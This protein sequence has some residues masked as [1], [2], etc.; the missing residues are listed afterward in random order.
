M[1]HAQLLAAA[2]WGPTATV[3]QQV[4]ATSSDEQPQGNVWIVVAATVALLAALV[5]MA[6]LGRRRDR[7]LR[8]PLRTS[9]TPA[10]PPG[11]AGPA[12]AAPRAQSGIGATG[13]AAR[14]GQQPPA[15]GGTRSGRPSGGPATAKPKPKPK[16]KPQKH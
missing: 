11:G 9:N 15:G 7:E 8:Q 14:R 5:A 16:P 12:K 6:A 3:L 1:G 10:P 4:A 13:P 2:G